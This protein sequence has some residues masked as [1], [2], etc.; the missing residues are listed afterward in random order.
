M[1]NKDFPL[2]KYLRAGDEVDIMAAPQNRETEGKLLLEKVRILDVHDIFKKSLSKDGEADD[3]K[4]NKNLLERQ[5]T[6]ELVPQDIEKI[7]ADA[8]RGSLI[9]SLQSKNTQEA[10][11]KVPAAPHK[12]TII[13]P[14]KKE[15]IHVGV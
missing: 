2:L 15:S 9:L 11:I 12:I 4:Q 10:T 5:V 1:I 14:N 7:L 3:D 13:R 6:V 8:R